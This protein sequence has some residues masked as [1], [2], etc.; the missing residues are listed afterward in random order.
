MSSQRN[1][2]V[3]YLKSEGE[4]NL[5]PITTGATE[6]VDIPR[7]EASN[8]SSSFIVL[9]TKLLTM[10]PQPLN[11]VPLV[12]DLPIPQ[13]NLIDETTPFWSPKEVLV[14]QRHRSAKAGPSHAKPRRGEVPPDI[15]A[16]AT[17]QQPFTNHSSS[18]M[19]ESSALW[20]FSA[21]SEVLIIYPSDL[22]RMRELYQILESVE[23]RMPKLNER[24]Y[25]S[26][27]SK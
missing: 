1:S 21:Q 5:L 19:P 20:A 13:F 2:F 4:E 18:T 3:V 16:F 17:I 26:L 27:R 11:T 25:T 7:T 24:A 15:K 10:A 23:L 12:D 14:T 8:S 22:E 9:G 6:P